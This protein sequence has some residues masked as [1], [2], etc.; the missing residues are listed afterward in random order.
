[1]RRRPNSPYPVSGTYE[2]DE[3]FVLINGRHYVL[4]EPVTVTYAGT[5]YPGY[6]QTWE[7]PGYDGEIDIEILLN[8]QSCPEN[9][10][11]VKNW[12]DKF[13]EVGDMVIEHLR[14]QG[15]LDDFDEDRYGE[16]RR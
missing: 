6:E 15:P 2:L 10:L 12:L 16:R 5:S 3:P 14:D 7:E 13:T 9:T 11:F 1:M 4:G 8:G